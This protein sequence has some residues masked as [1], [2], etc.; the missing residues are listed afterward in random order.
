M[1]RFA[2]LRL[3]LGMA[4]L[5]GAAAAAVLLASPYAPVVEPC[6]DIEDIWAIEDAREESDVP[7]V[8]ALKMN[9]V[10]L[11]YDAAENT[12]YCTLGL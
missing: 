12:F 2:R 6:R 3:L 8:T 11:A 9:G 10:P 1:K 4:A 7:L 5:L